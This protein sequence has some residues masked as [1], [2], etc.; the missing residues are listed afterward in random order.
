MFWNKK[1]DSNR[2][3]DL[4]PIDIPLRNSIPKPFQEPEE[5]DENYEKHKL[6]SFPDSPSQKKFS[7]VAIKDAIND[8]PVEKIVHEE[9]LPEFPDEKSLRFKTIEVD[10]S[11][12]KIPL[13]PETKEIRTPIMPKQKTSEV[14]VKIEKFNSARKSLSSIQQKVLQIEDLLKKIRETKMREEQEL[15]N[16]EKEISSV[17]SQIQEVNQNIFEHADE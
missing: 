3:P 14:F 2:L 6:P 1:E 10:E 16:W 12:T 11:R 5:D 4:P 17:K 8:K 15:S 9:D 7:E 13:P